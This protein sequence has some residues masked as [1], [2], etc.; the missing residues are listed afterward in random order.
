MTLDYEAVES[1][2]FVKVKDG[3]YPATVHDIVEDDNQYGLRVK[4]V[5]R[6]AN[7]K[8]EDG[9]PADLFK[10][11]NPKL[12]PKTNLG[13][14]YQRVSGEVIEFG[15]GKHYSPRSLIGKP[16][17]VRV[18]NPDPEK[19]S[20]IDD[21]LA[22]LS[23]SSRTPTIIQDETSAVFTEDDFC[24]CGKPIF[25]FLPNGRGVCE[26]HAEMLKG[27]GAA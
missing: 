14:W 16:C 27:F 25:T 10:W 2:R 3:T 12:S 11:C 13:I 22:P 9:G 21:I 19:G 18:V 7:Q 6:L 1:G 15:K 26:E 4:W 8:A 23:A 17:L 24:K 5:I 20:R